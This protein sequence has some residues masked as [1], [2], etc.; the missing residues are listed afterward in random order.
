MALTVKNQDLCEIA[1]NLYTPRLEKINTII[2]LIENNY[3]VKLAKTEVAKI[4]NFIKIFDSK[5]SSARKS[6]VKFEEKYSEWLQ[7][8]IE[9]LTCNRGA[10][11]KNR[12]SE[13]LSTRSDKAMFQE[14]LARGN[15]PKEAKIIADILPNASPL[16]LK[17]IVKSIPTPTSSSEFSEEEAIALM[18]ELGLSRNKYLILRNAL[19]AK[20]HDILP[21]YFAVLEKKKV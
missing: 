21:S 2:E 16:R 17:R 8:K 11:K 10:P 9:L 4:D 20:G 12:I 5:Y 19:I 18:F 3:K 13:S 6:K 7:S 1:Y 14:I 15:Q